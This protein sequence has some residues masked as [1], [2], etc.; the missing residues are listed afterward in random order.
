MNKIIEQYTRK[1]VFISSE[2][3]E[4]PLTLRLIFYNNYLFTNF[5][6]EQKL[7]LI[8]DIL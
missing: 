7:N 5:D 2:A 8:T 6:I 1:E 3:C 4:F